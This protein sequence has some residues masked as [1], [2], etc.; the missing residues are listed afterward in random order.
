MDV[1]LDDDLGVSVSDGVLL[2]QLVNK[3]HP[4]TIANVHIPRQ[5]EVIHHLTS[6]VAIGLWST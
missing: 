3:L 2:C 6:I 4:T 5:G 1:K